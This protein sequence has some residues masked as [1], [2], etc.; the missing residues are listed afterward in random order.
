MLIERIKS[1][2]ERDGINGLIRTGCE[3]IKDA[4]YSN[5]EAYY[6]VGN[7]SDAAC[8]MKAR[9][10]F[11][12]AI[13]D[14]NSLPALEASVENKK[15]RDKIRKRILAGRVAFL[16]I[17]DQKVATYWFA[18]THEE[19]ENWFGIR[20][21]PDREEVYFYDAHTF[22]EFRS[23]GYSSALLSEAL[24]YFRQRGY[25]RAIAIVGITNTPSIKVFIKNNFLKNKRIRTIRL[26]GFV[27]REVVTDLDGSDLSPK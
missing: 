3:I 17:V 9:E 1:K 16:G 14:K 8:G 7:L 15:L 4:I 22:P 26:T 19:Y 21:R 24:E 25:K 20:V 27:V 11:D 13:L 12:T 23:A 10:N 5:R 2:I 18:S 6:V